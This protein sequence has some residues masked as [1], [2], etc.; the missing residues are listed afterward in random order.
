MAFSLYE[1]A[2]LVSKSWRVA[3][4]HQTTRLKCRSTISDAA[5]QALA[6]S[7]PNLTTIDL[8]YCDKIT[9][10][11]VQALANSCPNL[12]SD[13]LRGCH[14]ITDAAAQALAN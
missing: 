11:A 8:T 4:N 3:K 2:S 12:T 7:C 13:N 14:N 6:N 10:A 5:V 1:I 9:D